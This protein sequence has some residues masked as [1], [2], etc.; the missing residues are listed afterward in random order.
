[1]TSPIP[2]VEMSNT[3]AAPPPAEDLIRLT[4]APA[5]YGNDIAW[6]LLGIIYVQL[7]KYRRNY[8]RDELL[9]RLGAYLTVFITTAQTAVELYCGTYLFVQFW[10]QTQAIKTP[11]RP[12]VFQTLFDGLIGFMVQMFFLWRIWVFVGRR[13]VGRVLCG[14]TFL[15]SLLAFACSL[16]IPIIFVQ[17]DNVALLKQKTGNLNIIWLAATAATDAFIA[18]YMLLILYDVKSR[19]SYTESRDAVEKFIRVTVQT[20]TLTFCVALM[21]LII[22]V[23]VKIGT[24]HTIGT[25]ILGKTYVLSLLLN[26]NARRKLSNTSRLPQLTFSAPSKPMPSTSNPGIITSN[27]L[28]L[29]SMSTAS[30]VDQSKEYKLPSFAPRGKSG[31]LSDYQ[32]TQWS[33]NEGLES[34]NTVHRASS[35]ATLSKA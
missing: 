24:L 25:Y 3:T 10:G 19:T 4:T 31:S 11:P 27:S 20:G 9:L 35:S 29:T 5:Y 7:Y 14:F 15:V 1:L 6:L 13:L 18:G 30:P 8:P 12:L 32:D 17:V 16:A 26:L 28:D 34:A 23:S 2:T 21:V 22:R 33:I